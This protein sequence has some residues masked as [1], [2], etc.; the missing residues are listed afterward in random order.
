MNIRR[1]GSLKAILEAAYYRSYKHVNYCF[2][3]PLK[4]KKAVPYTKRLNPETGTFSDSSLFNTFSPSSTPKTIQIII[5]CINNTRIFSRI[6]CMSI[7][8]PTLVT[9]PIVFHLGYF[10]RLLCSFPTSLI[11]SNPLTM[12][13][14]E[15]SLKNKNKK[16]KEK[17]IGMLHSPT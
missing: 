15:K 3:L 1:W 14:S 13:Q 16:K 5:Q 8:A 7:F 11:S 17:K 4:K 9:P 2:R 6:C 12:M 10:H